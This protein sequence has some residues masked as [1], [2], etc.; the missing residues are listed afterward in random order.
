MLFSKEMVRGSQSLIK[1]NVMCPEKSIAGTM[2]YLI[3]VCTIH[4]TLLR[5]KARDNCLLNFI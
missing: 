2:S 1:M 4:S 3:R 5:I